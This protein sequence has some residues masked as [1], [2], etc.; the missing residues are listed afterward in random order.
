MLAEIVRRKFKH[1]LEEKELLPD[2]VIV[3]G[4]KG[5]LSSA[6]LELKKL[7]LEKIP[8][9]GLAKEFESIFISGSKEPIGLPRS[10][11]ALH[12]LQRVR[13]EAHRFAHS[14]HRLLHGRVVFASSLDNIPG[15]GEKRRKNLLD[16]FGSISRIKRARLD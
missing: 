5:Q 16:R 11:K 4:G 1:A 8:V 13:D 14:Y 2:L 3:D 6:L 9:V 7:E 15:I 10:S 12:L